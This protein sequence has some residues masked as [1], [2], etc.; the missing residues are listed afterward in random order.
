LLAVNFFI[1][2]HSKVLSLVPVVSPK[3]EEK[4]ALELLFHMLIKTHA[5]KPLLLDLNDDGSSGF[6]QGMGAQPNSYFK[7]ERQ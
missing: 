6:V 7:L 1:Y 2:S 4:G 5:G 3:G